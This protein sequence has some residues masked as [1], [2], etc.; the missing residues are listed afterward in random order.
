M[1]VDKRMLEHT[2]EEHQY[3]LFNTLAQ[4]CP[5]SHDPS[6]LR[7]AK[8]SCLKVFQPPNFFLQGKS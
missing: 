8:L 1:R 6:V 7:N 5:I 3:S 4:S 2:K